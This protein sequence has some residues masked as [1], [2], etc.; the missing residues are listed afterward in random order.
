MYVITVYTYSYF[1][2]KPFFR[3][4]AYNYTYFIKKPSKLKYG[5]IKGIFIYY[6]FIH[7]KGCRRKSKKKGEKVR[8]SEI[9]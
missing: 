7:C 6:N 4:Y 1:S 9:F 5:D 3:G 8:Y 2:C